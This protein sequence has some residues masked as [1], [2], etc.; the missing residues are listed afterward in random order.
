MSSTKQLAANRAN[1]QSST[2]PR[3]P[4]GKSRS[5]A[6]ARKHSFAGTAFAIVKI[7]DRDAVDRLRADLIAV[8]QPANSQELFAIERI[9]IAQ[10]NLLR[11][12]KLEAGLCTFALDRAMSDLANDTP[13]VPLHEALQ[14]DGLEV[15]DQNQAF[16]LAQGFQ[17]MA[18]DTSATWSLF[19]RYQ[20]QA[21]RLYRRAIEEFERLKAL[22]PQL[23]DD[24]AHRRES[25]VRDPEMDLP[26]EANSEPQPDDNPGTSASENEANTEINT[27]PAPNQES[28]QAAERVR[29]ARVSYRMQS[30]SRGLHSPGVSTSGDRRMQLAHNDQVR[31]PRLRGIET[32]REHTPIG[33]LL[34]VAAKLVY[35]T[36]A[37]PSARA[38]ARFTPRPRGSFR[39]FLHGYAEPSPSVSRIRHTPR[40]PALH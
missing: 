27:E 31:L 15:K 25:V 16:C 23:P 11:L 30:G 35:K 3:T 28:P 33:V 38:L 13:F 2:G 20:S 1:A 22:R 6:N 24:E 19:L 32:H 37:C 36:T 9:A 12:A 14:V 5:A 8:Y 4:E 26:N 18:R 39:E 40:Q 10:H 29:C 21:E 34:Q 7:E 17:R